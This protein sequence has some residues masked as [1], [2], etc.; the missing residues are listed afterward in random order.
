MIQAGFFWWAA[1]LSL[2]LLG[3]VPSAIMIQQ[4][5]SSTEANAVAVDV[6][7]IALAAQRINLFAGM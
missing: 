6:L 5:V 1:A 3:V 7:K 4:V 2:C